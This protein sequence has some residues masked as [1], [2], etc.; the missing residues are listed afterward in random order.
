MNYYTDIDL[1]DIEKNLWLPKG[2][3]DKLGVWDGHIHIL[4]CI[5]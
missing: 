4:L 1:Q 2:K 5:K 3:G